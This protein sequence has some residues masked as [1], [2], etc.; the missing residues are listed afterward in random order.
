VRTTRKAVASATNP[1]G[2]ARTGGLA[3]GDASLEPPSLFAIAITVPRIAITATLATMARIVVFELGPGPA[4]SWTDAEA[5]VGSSGGGGTEA[6]GR[7]CI[8]MRR[9][10]HRLDGRTILRAPGCAVQRRVTT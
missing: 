3:D 2:G 9:S 6:I 1:P 8:T 7:R 4:G 10:A 5:G